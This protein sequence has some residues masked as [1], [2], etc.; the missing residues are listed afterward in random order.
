MHYNDHIQ[1]NESKYETTPKSEIFSHTRNGN[2]IIFYCFFT[3]L[4]H[5]FTYIEVSDYIHSPK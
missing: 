4:Y 2:E 5:F 1:R 3:S